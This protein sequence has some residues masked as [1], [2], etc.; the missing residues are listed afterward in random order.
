VSIRQVGLLRKAALWQELLK[1]ELEYRRIEAPSPE[2]YARRF[3]AYGHLLR[4]LLDQLAPVACGTAVS[5]PGSGG[6]H[7]TQD[8]P[9]NLLS[10]RPARPAMPPGTDSLPRIAGY[11]MLGEL[12]RGA[13]GVVYQARQI[14]LNRT[15]L[16]SR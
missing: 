11:E 16:P 13:M 5:E 4:P 3:P 10:S 9:G 8:A 7:D 12:G 1:L 6:R 2:E 14:S 15:R